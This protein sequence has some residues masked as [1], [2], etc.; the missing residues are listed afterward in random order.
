MSKYLVDN[1]AI[2]PE[3]YILSFETRKVKALHIPS[4]QTFPNVL[5]DTPDN[6]KKSVFLNIDELSFIPL[7]PY[8][9]MYVDSFMQV[10]IYD[11]NLCA[12]YIYRSSIQKYLGINSQTSVYGDVIIFGS[13]STK[14]QDSYMIDYSVPYEVIEQVSRYY[15]FN[16][17]LHD[18]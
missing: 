15:D 7:Q 1:P 9:H 18:Q 2:S 12:T 16:M 3:N 11:T 4:A 5:F 13:V 6:I 14:D 8:F 10:Q 17:V